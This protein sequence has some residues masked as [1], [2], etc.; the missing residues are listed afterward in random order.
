MKKFKKIELSL[1]K[2]VI[3]TLTEGDLSGVRGG[4]LADSTNFSGDVFCCI[5]E[6]NLTKFPNC[7]NTQ[8][9]GGCISSDYP[10]RVSC[11]LTDGCPELQTTQVCKPT[12]QSALCYNKP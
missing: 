4:N 12:N 8:I 1:E 5:P 3:S 9:E 10:S 7:I 11:K 2:E 6:S